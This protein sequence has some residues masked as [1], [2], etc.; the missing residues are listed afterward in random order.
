MVCEHLRS[1]SNMHL[2]NEGVTVNTAKYTFE[3]RLN[4]HFGNE[5]S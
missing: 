4:V 5:K 3:K 2:D 1:G